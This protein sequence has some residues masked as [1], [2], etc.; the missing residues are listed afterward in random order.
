MFYSG[1]DATCGAALDECGSA[2]DDKENSNSIVGDRHSTAQKLLKSWVAIQD[3][4]ARIEISRV[5]SSQWPIDIT[6]WPEQRSSQRRS[7]PETRNQHHVR[8][9][10]QKDNLT[11]LNKLCIE[12]GPDDKDAI[13][14]S[15]VIRRLSQAAP[16]ATNDQAT[17]HS[18]RRTSGIPDF[19]DAVYSMEAR[20]RE[21]EEK[22]RRNLNRSLTDQPLSVK[23]RAE[24]AGSSIESFAEDNGRLLELARAQVKKELDELRRSCAAS[25]RE[26]MS[27]SSKNAVHSEAEKPKKKPKGVRAAREEDTST[28]RG[29]SSANVLSPAKRMTTDRN[30]RSREI[31]RRRVRSLVSMLSRYEQRC[32][33]PLLR[34]G[35]KELLRATVDWKLLYG[36]VQA[37]HSR[38]SKQR[39][40]RAWAS[41]TRCILRCREETATENARVEEI[42]ACRACRVAKY[43]VKKWRRASANKGT[44]VTHL[45]SRVAAALARL[46]IAV[47]A[48]REASGTVRP[49]KKRKSQRDL[50]NKESDVLRPLG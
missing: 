32:R 34:K 38:L 42:L 16:R 15:R 11:K 28:C 17:R 39:H 5:G 49:P 3:E 13:L 23:E 6:A 12:R 8:D 14:A 29:S 46:P 10:K 31:W 27:L 4:T 35:F 37:S 47:P 25:E 9:L 18:N 43:V 41:L 50:N 21:R 22:R 26:W 44:E 48:T 40:L 1:L 7:M 33:R 19:D 2:R 20:R 45:H 36:K 24:P 30:P